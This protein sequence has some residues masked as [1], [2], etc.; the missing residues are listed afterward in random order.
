MGYI[1]ELPYNRSR[2]IKLCGLSKSNEVP[3]LSRDS[4]KKLYENP[5]LLALALQMFAEY[6]FYAT[7]INKG[8][9]DIDTACSLKGGHMINQYIRYFDF[10]QLRINS[11]QDLSYKKRVYDQ[12]EKMVTTFNKM[13]A[14]SIDL[15]KLNRAHKE[16]LATEASTVITSP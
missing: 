5:E 13:R 11:I 8:V 3:N 10:I 14:P 9:F 4:A 1:A 16:I 7:G 6:E 15:P 12:F 2:D